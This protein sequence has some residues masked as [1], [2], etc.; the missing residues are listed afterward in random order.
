MH[1]LVDMR[2][3][4]RLQEN[5]VLVEGAFV[6]ELA[7]LLFANQEDERGGGGGH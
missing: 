3:G 6:E 2:L 4:V 1:T 5:A 7:R